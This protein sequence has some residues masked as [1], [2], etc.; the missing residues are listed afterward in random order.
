LRPD[1]SQELS[2][3]Y[4]STNPEAYPISAYS[5]IVTQCA[6]DPQRPTCKGPYGNPG[7]AET[8]SKWLRY[9]AC[10]G[11]VNMARI[12]YSPLPPVLSQEVANSIARMTGGQ[13]EQL[14]ADNCANPTFRGSLG[15]GATSP[16][17]PL[18]DVESLGSGPGGGGSDSG[19]SGGSG[20]DGTTATGGSA[21]A[22]ATSSGGTRSALG[23]ARAAGGGTATF[24]DASPVAYQTPGQPAMAS[25]PLIALIAAISIPVVFGVGYAAGR[26]RGDAS[27]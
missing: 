26:R 13:P 8:L 10:D 21:G 17:N 27:P 20:T 16:K 25:G 14:N 23:A 11:Q 2:G 19:G 6:P 22:G 1:L 24:R 9:V 12:G 7:V 18:A 5:Y 3:V 15:A 4:A